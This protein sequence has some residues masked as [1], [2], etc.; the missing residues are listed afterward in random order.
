MAKVTVKLHRML[1]EGKLKSRASKD[2]L[3]VIELTGNPTVKDL[4]AQLEIEPIGKL[5]IVNKKASFDDQLELKTGD[6][7]DIHRLIAGG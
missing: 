7:I 2:E 3:F 4:L 5:V 1:L 6:Q